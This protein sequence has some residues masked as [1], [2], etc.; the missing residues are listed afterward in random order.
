MARPMAQ[1]M[2]GKAFALCAD[3][4]GLAPAIDRGIL[5]LAVQRRL[6]DVSCLVNGPRW[7]QA[8]RDL[9]AVAAVR[10]GHVRTGL[11]FNL[12]EGRPLSPALAALWPQF[13]PLQQLIVDAHLGRL[14]VDALRAEFSAQ[15]TAY[16][17]ARGRAPHHVDGHQHVHH[18][19]QV[20]DTVMAALAPRGDIRVRNTGLL[21][22]PGFLVK[23]LLIEGTGGRT[24]ARQLVT[25]RRHANTR[26]FGVYDFGSTDYR[27]LM[28]RWLAVLPP[29]GALLFCHPGEAVREAEGADSPPDPIAAARVRELAYL[30]SDGFKADLDAAGARLA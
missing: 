25:L 24:L 28:Q 20:R 6:S 14:P 5:Q 15:F 30:A 22:G 29:E 19:P 4:Y 2:P 23:R 3:D 16:E 9:V 18:L 11:H 26:L 10:Q 7:P 27:R 13:P 1:S 8:A 12:T 21:P 17:Q